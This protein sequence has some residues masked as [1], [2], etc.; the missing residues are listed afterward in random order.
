ME[1][2]LERALAKP[3][4]ESLINHPKQ[5]QV[6]EVKKALPGAAPRSRLP[7]EV[8]PRFSRGSADDPQTIEIDTFSKD[9]T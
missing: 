7:A 3:S 1:Y 2:E 6:Q 8:E 4:V 5:E 9:F